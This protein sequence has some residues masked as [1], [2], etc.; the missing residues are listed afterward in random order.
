MKFKSLSLFHRFFLIISGVAITP[1]VI[2][3]AYLAHYQ[4]I[5]KE[6]TL[7]FHRQLAQFSADLINDYMVSLN[8]R[9]AFTQD[10]ERATAIDQMEMFKVIQ[11]ALVTNPDFAVLSVLDKDG[12]ETVKL[13]DTKFLAEM[14]PMDRSKDPTFVDVAENGLVAVSP[15]HELQKMPVL[16]V[17]YPL[18]TGEYAYLTVNLT[19]LWKKLQSPKIGKTGKVLLVDEKGGLLVGFQGEDV[20]KVAPKALAE[21]LQGE[22]GAKDEIP[23][24]K[25][26]LVGGFR[27]VPAT[28][29]VAVTLQPHRLGRRFRG[30]LL[31]GAAH[32]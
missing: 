2:V 7:E 30:R 3:S 11:Q 31:C 15:V 4:R 19:G 24:E 23:G 9:L 29:W 20:P 27:F 14:A 22:G 5:A 32:L 8:K 12:K 18:R 28:L 17:V 13:A 16:N 1:L 21:M 26:K 6:N 25:E 10:L